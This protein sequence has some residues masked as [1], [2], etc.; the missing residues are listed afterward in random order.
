VAGIRIIEIQLAG[1]EPVRFGTR[2]PAD[3]PMVTAFPA[4]SHAEEP[5]TIDD[6]G[7]A[8]V[9]GVRD[10]DLRSEEGRQMMS[11]LKEIRDQLHTI[12]RRLN[13]LDHLDRVKQHRDGRDTA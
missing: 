10:S 8:I 4:H 7:A 3:H 6:A 1:R 5:A 13:P 2:W 11:V 9:A 12:L